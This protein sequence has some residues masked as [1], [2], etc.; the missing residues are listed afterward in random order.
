MEEMDEY[1]LR[2]K[3]GVM[4]PESDRPQLVASPG[5]IGSTQTEAYLTGDVQPEVLGAK[6]TLKFLWLD[7]ASQDLIHAVS[8]LK[9][10]ER[11]V[12]RSSSASNLLPLGSLLRL[13][14]LLIRDAPQFSDLSFAS[15]L[16]ELKSL[17]LVNCYAVSDLTPLA[18][19]D[20][21]TAF[22]HES[23]ADTPAGKLRVSS[24]APLAK[25]QTLE[26]LF[27]VG[28]YVSDESLEPLYNLDRL[29]TLACV[30][31]FPESQ[32]RILRELNPN[33]QCSWFE[34]LDMLG[35]LKKFQRR[36]RG[37]AV[38]HPHRSPSF[39]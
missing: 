13:K 24:L 14:Q 16:G 22:S 2:R 8:E 38:R 27:L 33:L 34:V 32:F 30:V 1:K 23:T 17:S 28:L 15:G 7:D 3:A 35:T 12:I 37:K 5:E 20:V 10:L 31:H 21:L 11:L 36:R 9:G 39:K 29:Q 6:Q 4:C 18:E 25:L 19:L 26:N